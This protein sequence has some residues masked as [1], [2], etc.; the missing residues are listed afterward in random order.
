MSNNL[1]VFDPKTKTYKIVDKIA[2]GDLKNFFEN[3]VL[4][5]IK[6][7]QR[8]TNSELERMENLFSKS[9]AFIKQETEAFKKILSNS[10]HTLV[11]AS[12]NEKGVLVRNKDGVQNA[13]RFMTNPQ[14]QAH[15]LIALNYN[16]FT[17]ALEE[18]SHRAGECAD[19]AVCV[20][21]AWMA[22]VNP[23]NP[24]DNVSIGG[25][26]HSTATAVLSAMIARLRDEF[27]QLFYEDI[28]DIIRVTA[29]KELIP[30]YSAEVHGHGI[31][32]FQGAQARAAEVLAERRNPRP[33]PVVHEDEPAPVQKWARPEANQ[34]SLAAFR[35]LT[36][37]QNA[38][39]DNSP[40]T[41]TQYYEVDGQRWGAILVALQPKGK[42][43]RDTEK[44]WTEVTAMPMKELSDLE[45]KELFQKAVDA[46]LIDADHILQFQNNLGAFAPN[47]HGYSV[48]E[49]CSWLNVGRCWKP[50]HL[51]RLILVQG[52]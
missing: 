13:P 41:L 37:K 46:G 5:Q 11:A 20:P 36:N 1:T 16:P 39:V 40:F 50:Y 10:P 3:E 9:E 35:D 15:G 45:T 14:I 29:R 49:D 24:N 31:I 21:T 7:P 12:F 4:P 51:A 27:P 26:G 38:I 25:G 28:L 42:F 23:L 33:A 48:E 44:T 6:D 43:G 22:Y 34:V 18:K 30:G 2:E 47:I 17:K 52:L 32:N 19:F 8:L